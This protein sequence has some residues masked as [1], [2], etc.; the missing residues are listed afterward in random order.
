MQRCGIFNLSMQHKGAITGGSNHGGDI[1][2]F[3]QQA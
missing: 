1:G 2:C 3:P